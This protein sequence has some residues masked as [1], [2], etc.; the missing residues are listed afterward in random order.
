MREAHM[1]RFCPQLT[2]H[3]TFDR[4]QAPSTSGLGSS[5]SWCAFKPKALALTFGS[6]NY[7]PARRGP[8]I[9]V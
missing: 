8:R 6:F 4:L 7:T 5:R 3:G 9:Q 2:G 1:I